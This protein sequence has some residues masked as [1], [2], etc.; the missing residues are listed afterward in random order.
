MATMDVFGGNGTDSFYVGQMFNDDSTARGVSTEDPISTT[1]TTKGEHLQSLQTFIPLPR[2]L[3]HHFFSF[4]LNFLR[5]L[6]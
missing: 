1:L 5:L 3:T 6:I 4:I 2:L